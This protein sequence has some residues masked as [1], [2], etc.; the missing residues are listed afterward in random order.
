MIYYIREPGCSTKIT[1]IRKAVDDQPDHVGKSMKMQIG[2]LNT[3]A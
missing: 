3:D 2:G 1:S